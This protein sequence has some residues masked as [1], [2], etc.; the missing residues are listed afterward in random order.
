MD[1]ITQNI[2]L[3]Q[4]CIDCQFS[5]IKDKQ[6]KED[7]TNDIVIILNDYPP[8]RLKEIYEEGHLNAFITGIINRNIN[9]VTSPYY[10]NY[11][12]FQNR[13]NEITPKEEDTIPDND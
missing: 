11:Y 13:T 5:K 9:S 4:T 10:K 8:E 3:I 1:I 7:L 12:R 6:F 2:D